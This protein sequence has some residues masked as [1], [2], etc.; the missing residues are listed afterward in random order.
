[1]TNDGRTRTTSSGKI[2]LL[3]VQKNEMETG[4]IHELSNKL[5]ID[6]LNA[7]TTKWE[8][9]DYKGN[10]TEAAKDILRVEFFGAISQEM[11]SIET[12]QTDNMQKDVI[13]LYKKVGPEKFVKERLKVYEKQIESIKL[14]DG[15]N[16][17]Q[18][19]K[20]EL[21]SKDD[22]KK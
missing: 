13:E 16:A 9:G 4:L 6:K 17:I 2:Y 12:G 8:N 5:S 11:Y 14:Q 21:E 3:R 20:K 7:I 1:M 22:G 19:Y 18:H 15:T 10:S